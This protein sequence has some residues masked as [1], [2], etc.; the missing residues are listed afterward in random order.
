MP[1]LDRPVDAQARIAMWSGPRNISTALMRAF[2]S[3]PDTAV[4]DEP[5]YAHY[6]AGHRR[7]APGRDEVIAAPRDGL[8]QGR[9]DAR[10]A[11]CPAARAI[12][13]QKHMAHHL[14]PK[15]EREWLDALDARVPDPRAARDARLAR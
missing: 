2:G 14:L 11:R 9:G 10:P 4:S 12:W 13:Y 8:A 3:R 5:L 6:L 7:R 15:I 1:T